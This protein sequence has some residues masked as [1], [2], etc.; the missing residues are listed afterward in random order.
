MAR[1]AMSTFTNS[2]HYITC[3]AWPLRYYWR[4]TTSICKLQHSQMSNVGIQSSILVINSSIVLHTRYE[5]WRLY[6]V[7]TKSLASLITCPFCSS[8]LTPSNSY[9]PRRYQ[10]F[11]LQ[12]KKIKIECKIFF[13]FYFFLFLQFSIA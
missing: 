6:K 10:F 5:L 4:S 11:F 3:F 8:T 9:C 1:L 7:P 12:L 13:I 2:L